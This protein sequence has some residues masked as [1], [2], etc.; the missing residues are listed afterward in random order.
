MARPARG[1]L[2]PCR[3]LWGTCERVEALPRLRRY[4]RVD[5]HPV[6]TDGPWGLFGRDGRCLGAGRAPVAGESLTEP[7]QVE[8][9]PLLFIGLLAL[10][11]G[12][13]VVNT[14]P[15]L[16]PLVGWTGPRPKLLCH[17]EPGSWHR[18]PFLKRILERLGY[19]L[20]DLVTFD[21]PVRLSDVL[22]PDPA[23]H[24]QTRVHTVYGDLC[25]MVGEGFWAASEADSVSR[26]V[27][28]AKT[29]LTSG[30]TRLV[31][32]IEIADELDRHGVEIV[33]PET[34]DFGAQIRLMSSRR[35]L[36]GT[37]GS[38]FHGSVF[39]APGRRLVGLN[40]QPAL[41]ANFPLLDGLNGTQGRYYHAPG[42]VLREPG[43]FEVSWE[44]PDPRGLAR[45]LLER[46]E[47]L[48]RGEPDPRTGIWQ[49]R[50]R[51]F[52][53]RS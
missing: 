50:I 43:A 5:F 39:A 33:T 35:V 48:D 19:R 30:V 53:S 14:L 8:T 21:R 13:F 3:T 29:R 40:W 34:L 44:V 6:R 27:Y 31:N 32:E 25:R 26:P 46:A 15:H 9:G 22:V 1:R 17:A 18:A 4:G 28:L 23:L 38:A 2:Q 20:D 41:N 10:H 37:V 24:E 51:G 36:L 16:W 7:D 42:T 12:H 52:R 11:Y 45:D 49:R 47:R